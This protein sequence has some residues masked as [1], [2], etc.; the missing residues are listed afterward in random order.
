MAGFSSL[1]Y[2]TFSIV[3]ATMLVLTM[4]GEIR[5]QSFDLEKKAREVAGPPPVKFART[6]HQPKLDVII[7]VFDPN[8]PDKDKAQVWPEVRRAE[9]NRFALMTKQALEKSGAFGA[10][11]V[12]PDDSAFGEIYVH[13]K[14]LRANGEDVRIE[15]TVNDIRGKKKAWIKKKIF[16]HR[17]QGSFFHSTRTRGTDAYAPVFDQIAVEI[18]KVLSKKKKKDLKNL[19]SITQM[20]FA[21]MFGQEYFGKYTKV[22]GGSYKL[23]GLPAEDDP[24]YT[25]IQ[26]M[27]IQEQM[28]VDSLQPHYEAFATKMNPHYYAWQEH[29]MPIARERR[30]E[31][32][33]ATWAAIGAVALGAAAVASDSRTGSTIAGVGAGLLA[34]KSIKDFGDANASSKV[35]DEMGDTLNLDMGTQVVEFEGVQTELTG[36]AVE[37][38]L[39]YRLHLKKI[40]E[41]ERTPD[42][43]I[44]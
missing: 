2:R 14:I 42:D 23:V 37:Q 3:L 17:V 44:A 9:A 13:G 24:I 38:F 22:K 26:T 1:V 29:A 19:A 40:F 8:I 11:R 43:V 7:P 39:G 16:K 41:L 18:V 15:I 34:V 27:R 6:S 21:S 32:K 30:K 33:K 31:K 12:A 25:K 20:R 10:V 36:D 35:L 28:F 4:G 5:A